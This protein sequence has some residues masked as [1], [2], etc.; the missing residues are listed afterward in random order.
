MNPAAKAYVDA[1][2]H[3]AKE[4]TIID[5]RDII[6]CGLADDLEALQR[7]VARIDERTRPPFSTSGAPR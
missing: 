5:T 4:G 3:H 1:L 7:T 2:R 6:I